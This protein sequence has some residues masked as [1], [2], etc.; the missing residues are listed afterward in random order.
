MPSPSSRRI[1]RHAYLLQASKRLS[2]VLCPN[3]FFTSRFI[4]HREFKHRG[5][6]LWDLSFGILQSCCWRS[7]TAGRYAIDVNYS[8]PFVVDWVVPLIKHGEFVKICDRRIN[9][10]IQLF[11][12]SLDSLVEPAL[13]HVLRPRGLCCL[14]D[15]A[16]PMRSGHWPVSRNVFVGF[17]SCNPIHYWVVFRF[18]V[19]TRLIIGSGS[20]WTRFCNRVSR[21]DTNPT[22]W[23]ELP[24]LISVA[25]E[26]DKL[27]SKV[28]FHLLLR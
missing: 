7:S 13:P 1:T 22:R 4:L 17:V 3:S 28:N 11:K 19:I 15:E 9:Y 21:V 16:V 25:C 26:I 8:P 14:W 2:S 20:C 27:F 18:E 10:R 12:P 24:S 23:P 6:E 5:S